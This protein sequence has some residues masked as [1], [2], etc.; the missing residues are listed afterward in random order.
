[1]DV[2]D[3]TT[4]ARPTE[5]ALQQVSIRLVVWGHHPADHERA[6]EHA[7]E[8]W[9]RRTWVLTVVERSTDDICPIDVDDPDAIAAYRQGSWAYAA[10]RADA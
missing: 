5:A 4:P 2:I 1:M 7:L 8:G 9:G 3:R 6:I 10:R